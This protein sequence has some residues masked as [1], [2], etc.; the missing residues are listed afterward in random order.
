MKPKPTKS[1][2][3]A[4]AVKLAAMADAAAY[5]AMAALRGRLHKLGWSH[6]AIDCDARHALPRLRQRCES[7]T[8]AMIREMEALR[9]EMRRSGSGVD[10]HALTKCFVSW[11]VREAMECADE[12]N[13]VHPA[14]RGVLEGYER[15]P[16]EGL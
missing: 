8:G 14:G 3:A 1:A 13:E 10:D 2:R 4:A 6:T 11:Y 16:R 9:K 15:D 12:R 5:R 7:I